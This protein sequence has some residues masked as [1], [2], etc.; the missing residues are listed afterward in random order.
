[1][2]FNWAMRFRLGLLTVLLLAFV[3]CSAPPKRSASAP[4]PAAVPAPTSGLEPAPQDT[5]QVAFLDVGQ[6]DSALITFPNGKTMLVDG[7]RDQRGVCAGG[8]TASAGRAA[9]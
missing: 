1:M 3:A 7:G 5:L 8:Q 6:G 4:P 9:D 2:G